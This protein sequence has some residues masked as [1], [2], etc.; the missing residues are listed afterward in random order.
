M[1]R[2]SNASF[3]TVKTVCDFGQLRFVCGPLRFQRPSEDFM[4]IASVVDG[5]MEKSQDRSLLGSGDFILKRGM[6]VNGYVNRRGR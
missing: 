3:F 4:K 5:G 1:G 2:R 6:P